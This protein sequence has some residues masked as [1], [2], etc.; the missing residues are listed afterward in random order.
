MTIKIVKGENDLESWCRKNNSFLL[1]EWDYEKNNPVKPGDILYKSAAK[2]HWKC[3][4]CGNEWEA[5]PRSRTEGHGCKICGYKK[6]SETR[7]KTK[8]G[9][10][11]LGTLFPEVAKEWDYGKNYP[12]TPQ[13]VKPNSEKITPW[14]ICS[15][16]HSYKA[17]LTN[18]THNSS[19]CPYCDGKKALEGF[20]DFAN[21]F[22]KI[23]E[24]WDY[25]K[26]NGLKPTQITYGSKKKVWWICPKGHHYQM[27]VNARTA[28]HSE[29]PVCSEAR[30]TSLPEQAVL[31]YL[32]KYYRTESR[33]MLEGKEADIFL[34]DYKIAIEYDGMYYHSKE[35]V[36]QRDK[37]KNE[38]FLKSGIRLIRIKETNGN[39]TTEDMVIQYDRSKGYGN[40]DWAINQLFELLNKLTGN[41]YV[42]ESSFKADRLKI[43]EGYRNYEKKNN[44]TETN[45]ELIAEWNREKNGN[46]LPEY[47]TSGSSEKVWWRCSAYH[48][49]TATIASRAKGHGCPFCRGI[50]HIKGVNDLASAN[51]EL[52]AEWDYKKNEG[53]RP[54]NIAKGSHEKVWWICPKGHSYQASPLNRTNITNHTGCPYCSNKK[55][56][57]GYND[58]ATVFPE[59]AKEWDYTKNGELKPSEVVYGSNK[60]VY[61]KC[62]NCGYSW[63]CNVI[64]KTKGR[65]CPNCKNPLSY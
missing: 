26:N 45:P 36:E 34:P 27:T 20:N 11:D 2:Y 1:K 39:N 61:W 37:K 57:L 43:I 25:E 46:L 8:V 18:R 49:W 12:Y 56:L 51:P 17:S 9:I 5:T 23:A 48:E 55:V 42:C 33:Y 29:C 63:K 53:I 60:T 7:K 22:P 28:N 65:K 24:E 6:I 15:L 21:R 38:H 13:D 3:S 19:G 32:G 50:K 35:D 31:Y 64:H 4:E 59:H 47:Y 41:N 40:I 14:W 10:N 54:E 62:S 44:L 16:G 58:L 52:L 30:S